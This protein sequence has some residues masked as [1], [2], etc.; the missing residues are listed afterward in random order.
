MPPTRTPAEVFIARLIIGVLPGLLFA[1]PGAACGAVRGAA[2]GPEPANRLLYLPLDERFGT[3]DLFLEYA[4][5][6]PFSVVT[7]GARL[8]PVQKAPPAMDDLMAWFEDNARSCDVFVV[9]ADLLLYGGL[10]PSR[11]GDESA[12]LIASRL[13]R[14]AATCRAV[15]AA[16]PAVRIFVSSTVM[17]IPAYSSSMEEPDYYARYGRDLFEYSYAYQKFECTGAPEDAK[18]RDDAEVRIPPE[19]L[20][21]WLW[22]RARN[23]SSNKALAALAVEKVINR[24]VVTLD[25]NATHGI[26]QTETSELLQIAAN[27]TPGTILIHQG[28]DEAQLA[29]L[30]SLQVEQNVAQGSKEPRVFVVYRY[31]DSRTRVPAFEGAPLDVPVARHLHSTGARVVTDPGEATCIV[32]INNFPTENRFAGDQGMA[33]EPHKPAPPPDP[34]P[35]FEI[36]IRD[37]GLDP[38]APVAWIVADVHYYNGADDRLVRALLQSNLSPGRVSYA[39]WNTSGNTLGSALSL[40]VLL[41]TSK[42]SFQMQQQHRR[43]LLA[44][45][46]EDWTYM[47]FAREEI[48]RKLKHRGMETFESAEVESEFIEITKKRLEEGV[49]QLE[50][51][52]QTSLAV[53]RVWF[54]WHR[55]FEVGFS[56]V[57]RD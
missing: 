33:P 6:T 14:F 25:D 17:R 26:F 21:N 40:G 29:L 8:L 4:K 55:T 23:H 52:L 48:R 24:L 12:A 22:R 27:A 3:R 54:P 13:N 15:R 44:R 39:G 5:L 43:I 9:S 47:V 28:A 51:W 53:D 20:Q 11:C 36:W 45:L 18:A 42:D 57:P 46:L 37:A 56:L 31:P 49:A 7:P 32:Y 30:A 41:A 35:P 16:R 2:H 1:L 19:I 50:P 10:A 34:V 38:N